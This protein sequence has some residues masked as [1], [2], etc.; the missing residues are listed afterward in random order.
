MIITISGFPGSGTTTLS[1]TLMDRRTEEIEYVN[2]GDIFRSLA[3]DYEMD[4]QT[5]SKHV[6]NNPEIDKEIDAELRSIVKAFAGD[7][8]ED[9]PSPT[10]DIN[11]DADILLLE[12]RLA[13]WIA[14]GY[15]TVSI[16]CQAPLSVR[17]D[18]IADQSTNKDELKERQEDEQYRYEH[19]YNIDITDTKPYDLVVGTARWSVES[20]VDNVNGFITAYDGEADE[21]P[22]S[23][24]KEKLFDILI[25]EYK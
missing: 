16:W 5:F 20:I 21:M 8:S 15:S 9:K 13:G 4:L 25:N 23:T 18:R 12:S 3:D 1:E 22:S 11:R 7:L 2:G 10:I 14:G 17:Q 24:K 6:N 19:W